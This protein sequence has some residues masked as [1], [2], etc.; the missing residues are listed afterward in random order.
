MSTKIYNGYKICDDS[1][2]VLH[3]MCLDVGKEYKKSVHEF[4]EKR[5]LNYF[6]NYIDSLIKKDRSFLFSF[7][8]KDPKYD[9]FSFSDLK[10]EFIEHIKKSS[11]SFMRNTDSVDFSL[12]FIPFNHETYILL[13]S[14]ADIF[15]E[16][17]ENVSKKYG[18]F[19]Y[20]YWDNVDEPENISID[21]W[22]K[23]EN[24]WNNAL[25]G[26][27]FSKPCDV[28]LIYEPDYNESL[29]DLNLNFEYLKNK[30]PSILDK[31]KRIEKFLNRILNYE[32]D[33]FFPSDDI[34]KEYNTRFSNKKFKSIKSF[35]SFIEEEKPFLDISKELFDMK[36]IEIRNYANN[37]YLNFN[38]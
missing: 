17:F 13:Y 30:Y 3:K 2:V 14:S 1:F 27:G 4:C 21:E 29:F 18:V 23:R 10:F 9:N 12:C 8:D 6:V 22:N 20:F 7:L 33:D 5:F 35:R 15:T 11:K 19:E 36:I 25:G 32:S 16:V 24:D 28:G 38:K 26:D 31:N 37:F 34:I